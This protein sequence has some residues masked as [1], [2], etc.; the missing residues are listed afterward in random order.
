MCP[1]FP[2]INPL[3]IGNVLESA[4]SSCQH[5]SPIQPNNFDQFLIGNRSIVFH[6]PIQVLFYRRKKIWLQKSV[7]NVLQIFLQFLSFNNRPL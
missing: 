5:I 6:E 2:A 3:L 7:K 4:V 1:I